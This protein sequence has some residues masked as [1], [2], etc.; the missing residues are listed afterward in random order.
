MYIYLGL[1]AWDWQ[2]YQGLLRDDGLFFF[3]ELL[4]AYRSSIM[5]GTCEIPSILVELLMSF[6]IQT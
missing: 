4:I 5:V 2:K 3:Q 1:D 6:Y